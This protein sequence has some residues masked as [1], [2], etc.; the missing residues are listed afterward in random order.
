M[1]ERESVSDSKRKD[2]RVMEKRVESVFV[3]LKSI[4]FQVVSNK[5]QCSK[6][7]RQ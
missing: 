1:R 6:R 5:Q 2:E 3:P 7:D 4:Q